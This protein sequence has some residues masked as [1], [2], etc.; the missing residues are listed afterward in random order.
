MNCRRQRRTRGPFDDSQRTGTHGGQLLCETNLNKVIRPGRQGKEKEKEGS[1]SR[2]ALIRIEATLLCRVDEKGDV[3]VG[4]G[5][6]RRRS[7]SAGGDVA[8]TLLKWTDVSHW[9]QAT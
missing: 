1:E 7:W 4:D 2:R 8:S 6:F 9:V 5:V 3:Q